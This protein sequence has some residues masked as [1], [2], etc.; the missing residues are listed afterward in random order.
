MYLLH[1]ARREH[2][3]WEQDVAE[4]VDETRDDDTERPNHAVDVGDSPGYRGALSLDTSSE[5]GNDRSD[6][7]RR[8]L[9]VPVWC[10]N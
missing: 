1:L 5:T 7:S 10:P 6:T 8:Q 2:L 4:V 9:G 3:P